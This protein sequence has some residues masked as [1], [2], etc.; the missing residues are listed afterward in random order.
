MGSIFPRCSIVARNIGGTH[1]ST[2]AHV[3]FTPNSTGA[4][5]D[6]PM[7]W[8]AAFSMQPKLGNGSYFNI[9]VEDRDITRYFG[10]AE[11]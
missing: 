2:L 7:S 9:V 6:E 10:H 5:A 3:Y 1:Y 8:I 11:L 4:P